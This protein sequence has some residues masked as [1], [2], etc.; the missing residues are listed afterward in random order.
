[1]IDKQIT[2]LLSKLI[3]ETKSGKRLWVNLKN[4]DVRP[5]SPTPDSF[6]PI[7]S[8]ESDPIFSKSYFTEYKN[9]R[10]YLL[11]FENNFGF[12]LN[13]VIFSVDSDSSKYSTTLIGTDFGNEYEADIVSLKR[14]YNL[15]ENNTPEIYSLINEFLLD[16]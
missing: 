3:E 16:D 7:I 14:L 15:V 11:F 5:K 10:F 4:S 1:M 13:R 6:S 9:A 12:G 2:Q 8:I